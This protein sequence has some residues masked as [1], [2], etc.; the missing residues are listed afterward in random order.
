METTIQKWGNS[1]GV[2][3]PKSIAT[4]QS[5]TAG[6]RVTVKET[7]T[8]ISIEI[9]KKKTRTLAD[10][11]KGITKDNLHDEVDWGKPVGSEIW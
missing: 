10:M 7:K 5:L 11:L 1:L 8:G 2:R 3:L 4:N 6:S 9:A